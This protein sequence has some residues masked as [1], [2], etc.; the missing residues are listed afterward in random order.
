MSFAFSSSLN[1][2]FAV[3][4]ESWS[5]YNNDFYFARNAVLAFLKGGVS[6]WNE[7]FYMLDVMRMGNK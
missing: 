1:N 7:I 6:F 4:K 2:P 5:T 3:Q